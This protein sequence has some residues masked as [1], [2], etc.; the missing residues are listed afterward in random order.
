MVPV[1][2]LDGYWIFGTLIDLFLS[3]HL[4]RVA[5]RVVHIILSILGTTL[6]VLNIVLGV[7]SLL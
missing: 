3:A 5:R 2:Y 6:L 7:R 4:D 1:F